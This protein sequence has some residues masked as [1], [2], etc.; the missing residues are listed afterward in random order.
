MQAKRFVGEEVLV[1]QKRKDP[2]RDRIVAVQPNGDCVLADGRVFD[3]RG[4]CKTSNYWED[5][6]IEDID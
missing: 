4:Q 6:W 5:V 3:Y 1:V 2:Y